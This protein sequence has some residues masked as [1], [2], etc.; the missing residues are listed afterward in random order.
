MPASSQ[1]MPNFAA[2]H[3]S[4]LF[5]AYL[6]LSTTVAR[7]QTCMAMPSLKLVTRIVSTTAAG[8]GSDRVISGRIGVNTERVF[9]GVQAGFTGTW[10][11]RRTTSQ[12]GLD[13]GYTVRL[14]S[15]ELCPIIQSVYRSGPNTFQ[16]RQ[17]RTST[18]A[19]LS[20]GRDFQVSPSFAYVPYAQA[21]ILHRHNSFTLPDVQGQSAPHTGTTD[22]LLGRVSVGLGLRLNDVVTVTPAFTR[23]FGAG[24]DAPGFGLGPRRDPWYS[25]S[26]SYGWRRSSTL[27]EN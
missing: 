12:A 11:L 22:K 10:L 1:K 8:S 21:G 7:A 6:T 24:G 26:V 14:G 4:V 5:A 19:G 2:I 3:A 25:I 18:F 27:S 15:A 16:A 17:S 20:I 13:L 23:H 9:V